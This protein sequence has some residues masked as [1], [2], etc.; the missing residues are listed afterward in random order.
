MHLMLSNISSLSCIFNL[1][2]F[3]GFLPSAFKY[4]S[5]ISHIKNQINTYPSVQTSPVIPLSLFSRTPKLIIKNCLLFS[6][7]FFAFLSIYSSLALLSLSMNG[8]HHK[9]QC[10]Y[11]S[12][13]KI[14]ASAQIVFFL[15]RL[16]SKTLVTSPFG[17]SMVAPNSVGCK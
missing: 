9:I 2:L 5:N 4:N 8:C 1:H 17:Y 3:S 12:A 11:A 15:E 14:T 16:L 13:V 10:A 6:L 7:Y